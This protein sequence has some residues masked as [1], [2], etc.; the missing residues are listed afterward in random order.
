[1]SVFRSFRST[2]YLE[3]AVLALV[4]ATVALASPAPLAAEEKN[5]KFQHLSLK[6]GL[7]QS[8]VQCAVQDRQGYLWFGT[9]EGLGRYDGYRFTF[10]AHDAGDPSSLSHN[11]IM[12]MIEDDG[13]LWLGTEGGGLDHFDPASKSFVHYRYDP[14]DPA[15][16]SNDR[17]RALL[18]DRSGRLWV[19]TD[20]G[21]VNLLDTAT[22]RFTRFQHDPE[23][24]ASLSHDHARSLF[25][26]ASGRLWVG[27]D[28][29][30]VSRLD[31]ETGTFT[32][33]RHDPE[34]PASLSS[35]QV[36]TI[37]GDRDGSLWVGTYESG[38]NRLDRAASVGQTAIITR[39][40]HDAEDPTSLSADGV[41]TIYQ[42]RD[43]VLW[44]GTDSGLSE[45]RPSTD[46]FARYRHDP[47]DPASLAGDRVL[48][49]YQ[50]QG[51]VLWV[52]TYAGLSKWNTAFGSILHYRHRATD[53][54]PLSTDIVTSF[55]EADDGTVWVGTW[56]GGLNRLQPETGAFQHYRH[57]PSDRQS[58]GDDRI[59]SLHVEGEGSLWI[60][61]FSAGL[62]R[63]DPETDTFT[64]FV[65]DPT[66]PN[67]LAFNGVTFIH[68]DSSDVLWV[69]TYRGGLN[70]LERNA[71]TGRDGNRFT[72]FR[73]DPHNPESLSSD[74]VIAL[75]EDPDG[76]LW[77][78]TEGA[79]LNHFDPATGKVTAHYRHDPENAR[80]IASDTPWVLRRGQEGDLWIGTQGGGLNLWSSADRRAGRPI[81]RRYTKNEGLPSDHIFGILT[82][83]QGYLWLSSNRG[84]TRFD[85]ET[86]SLK[87]FDSSH[88]LQSDEFN[89]GAALQTGDGRMY[90]GGISGFNAFHPRQVHENTHVPPVM[91][92]EFLKFNDAIDLGRPLSEVNH[93]TLD[94]QDYV[95]AFE[96]AALDFTAPEKNRYLHKLEGFDRDWVDSGKLRRAT[97]TNL[98]PGDYTF[99]VKASNND[100]VWN[101]Q[102]AA[103]AIR[104]EPPPWKTWWA[105]SLYSLA[106]ACA[107][108]VFTSA[109]AKKRQR[110]A[111]LARANAELQEEIS[112]RQAKEEA[113]EQ[114]KQKAQSYFDVAGVIMVVLD[115][116]GVVSLI[117]QKGCE[118]LG[119]AEEEIVGKSWYHEFVTE[120]DSGA[121]KARIERGDFENAYKYSVLTHKWD[122][123]IIEWHTTRL[124]SDEGTMA[125]TLSSGTDITEVELLKE[126]KESAESASRAKS[127]FLANMSHEIRTPMNGLLG[128]IELL[129]DDEL[130]ERQHKFAHTARQSARNLLDLLNDILDFSKIEAGKLE[131]DIVDFSL[132][133]L[134][135]EVAE[136]F[137]EPCHEKSLE[138]LYSI[139]GD[140]RTALRGDPIRLRQ[141]LSNLISNAIKF[142]ERGEVEVKASAEG[143]A[144][145]RFEV[146]DTGIGLDAKARDRIFEAFHQADGSTTRKYGGTGLGLS[147]STE[148][149]TLMGGQMGV[150]S[151]PGEG[152]SFWFT[153]QL[154]PA[155]KRPG[156]TRYPNFGSDAPQV[157]VVDDNANSRA[158][159][160]LQLRDWGLKVQAAANGPQAIQM[161]LSASVDKAPFD[162]ALVDQK[163]AGMDG[164]ELAEAVR[165]VPTLKDLPVVM[166]TISPLS[167]EDLENSGIV[168]CISKPVHQPELYACIAGLA[169]PDHKFVEVPPE[170]AVPKRDL[171]AARILTVEDNPINQ[172]VV[173]CMLNKVGCSCETAA[174]GPTALRMVS[175]RPYDLILMDCQMPMM[176][177][178]EVTAAIREKECE[179]SLPPNGGDP[180]QRIPIIAM[181]ANVLKGD[182]EKCLA[183]GMDDYLSKPFRPEQLFE[184]LA[185]WLPDTLDS[186]VPEASDAETA[187]SRTAAAPS[188]ETSSDE[189]LS[190]E[191]LLDETLSSAL[192]RESL[193]RLR[194]LQ[195]DGSDDLLDRLVQE[196][197]SSTPDLIASMRNEVE[198]GNANAI[199][200]A[201]HSLKSSS[202][203]LGATK[204]VTLCQSLE[205]L[206][207]ESAMDEVAETLAALEP[208]FETARAALEAEVGSGL[209]N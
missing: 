35:D 133:G 117:N 149:V 125:G 48:S 22:G 128:M 65:H 38:L 94:H 204:M 173:Q 43:G 82:D 83:D 53:P 3:C 152:S 193:D 153:V 77:I 120:K 169:T 21:G 166:L 112:Q 113:L 159:L 144:G 2:A 1:M 183:A 17:V 177:G 201:A 30:G 190:D 151:A 171:G 29:G 45:W 92:T 202:G 76:T 25:E 79:G 89:F 42:D 119:Y 179:S 46:D 68:R 170:E 31:P 44:V 5:V 99:R 6:E 192:D 100:G 189:T 186:S 116:R 67:S 70:R 39:F 96:F 63:Y 8:F 33:F 150:E 156:V 146:R 145:L 52:G 12:T 71:D 34:D 111:E 209:V 54:S 115:H 73:H 20:G 11:T 49:I 158:C 9:Q 136:L 69:G 122:I 196:F 197:V 93:L 184:C 176:D 160:Q 187:E 88:G 129:L 194:E 66:N 97:Y 172:E 165:A 57:D 7:S 64:R 110:A 50:D 162:V 167:P 103:L 132:R 175:T 75:S 61:T 26:D 87:N 141:I 200:E 114:A 16:L 130:S 60:G 139:S 62:N 118:V 23:N 59:M 191:T 107:V 81:F 180:R 84:L 208:A 101:E 148:L 135:Q 40:A 155:A 106:L 24:P 85:P 102:G 18:Q 207:K 95:V 56:G 37:Y 188:A 134:I 90:F 185:S 195:R 19:G 32:H 205:T 163:M 4:L 80:S 161:L 168:R 28:G 137:A 147:I 198:R 181:T 74:I 140:T 121:V 78:G 91:L 108:L 199:K 142:T 126:A 109:Q 104:V 86:E 124:P 157:L 206:A 14:D 182:R 10:Y 164:L 58:L 47:T 131:L 138:L 55:A 72:R 98:A 41:Y 15:S 178:Y 51:G 203:F 123:R 127:Q 13:T 143:P 105:Y 27:T 154:E 36:K 174:D